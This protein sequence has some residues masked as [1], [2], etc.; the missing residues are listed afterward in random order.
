MCFSDDLDHIADMMAERIRE[1]GMGVLGPSSGLGTRGP[2]GLG[3]GVNSVPFVTET[4]TLA[5]AIED[6]K[7]QQKL[8]TFYL[9]VIQ[10]SDCHAI[11]NALAHKLMQ[12]YA[13]Q[14]GL[15]IDHSNLSPVTFNFKVI[16][17]FFFV[18]FFYFFLL[19]I[20]KYTSTTIFAWVTKKKV[21]V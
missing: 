9:S 18:C 17:L 8:R 3:A 11:F 2:S 16:N 7:D 13:E 12:K 4:I 21:I 1:R 6:A 19:S 20:K 10:K 14:N 15:T 5:T